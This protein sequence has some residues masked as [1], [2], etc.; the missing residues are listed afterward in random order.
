MNKTSIADIANSMLLISHIYANVGKNGEIV[1]MAYDNDKI[2]DKSRAVELINNA[3][4]EQMKLGKWLVKFKWEALPNQWR[5]PA[6]KRFYKLLYKEE[7]PMHAL[8]KALEQ[9]TGKPLKVLAGEN[10]IS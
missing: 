10:Q 2:P 1:Y 6:V 8:Q 3:T 5:T 7:T 4:D 9:V